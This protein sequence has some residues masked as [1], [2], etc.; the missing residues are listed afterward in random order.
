MNLWLVVPILLCIL[1][2]SKTIY[3]VEC[4]RT[5][6]NSTALLEREHLKDVMNERADWLDCYTQEMSLQSTSTATCSWDTP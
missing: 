6:R 2:Y 3:C 4:C 1:D 5:S